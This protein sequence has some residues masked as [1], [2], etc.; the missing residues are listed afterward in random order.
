MAFAHEGRLLGTDAPRR[1]LLSAR[2]EAVV[3]D[4]SAPDVDGFG[5]LTPCV[6]AAALQASRRFFRRLPATPAQASCRVPWPERPAPRPRIA[7]RCGE[8]RAARRWRPARR[9]IPAWGRG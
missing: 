8:F 4:A 1:P 5:G 6:T 2:Q 3:R 9:P 7:L